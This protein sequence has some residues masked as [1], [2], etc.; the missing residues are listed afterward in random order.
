MTRKQDMVGYLGLELGYVEEDYVAQQQMVSTVASNPELY[1]DLFCTTGWNL[2][3]V[4]PFPR[5]QIL[6]AA[7]MLIAGGCPVICWATDTAMLCNPTS[8]YGYLFAAY[9]LNPAHEHALQTAVSLLKFLEGYAG[10]AR[11]HEVA[12]NP[13]QWSL[14]FAANL[15][16]PD[17]AKQIVQ[18]RDAN[19]KRQKA[20][21]NDANDL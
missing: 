7:Q 21:F 16:L 8:E 3:A 10:N 1:P 9:P 4:A 19:A 13:L 5:K 12:H 14:Q 6:K 17:H 18:L 15:F 11:I 20:L 2:A